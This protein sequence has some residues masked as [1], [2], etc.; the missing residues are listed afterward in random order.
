MKEELFKEKNF[1][2]HIV[3]QCDGFEAIKVV[4]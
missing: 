1:E 2:M 4:F 3:S